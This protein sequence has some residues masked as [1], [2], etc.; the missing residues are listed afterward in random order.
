MHESAP[1]E[2][3][4]AA[5]RCCLTERLPRQSEAP[6]LARA[7]MRAFLEHRLDA[8]TVEHALLA[9]SELVTNAVKFADGRSASV[10]L[11]VLV[12]PAEL[13]VTVTNEGGHASAQ[14]LAGGDPSADVPGDGARA[15]Q[16][17]IAGGGHDEQ[18]LA[19]SGRGLD[20]VRDL[21]DKVAVFCGGVT[22][23]R[24]ATRLSHG[25]TWSGAAG[26]SALMATPRSHAGEIALLRAST[27][28]TP[29]AAPYAAFRRSTNSR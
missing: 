4:R 6:A 8:E 23:V 21:S 20:I 18:G 24:A 26:G 14:R 16:A 28:R 11:H 7:L 22:M 25:H 3:S 10:W 27:R 29:A 12:T 5:T 9:A 15:A 1:Y 19:E 17:G 2:D 13:A